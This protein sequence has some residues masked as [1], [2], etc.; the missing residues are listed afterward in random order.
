MLVYQ[1]ISFLLLI[2]NLLIVVLPTPAAAET[3]NAGHEIKGVD[4]NTADAEALAREL[5]GIGPKKA[6]AIVE[7]REKNG[8]FKSLYELDQVYGIG[9]KTIER[10]QEKIIIL[11]PEPSEDTQA[12]EEEAEATA[13]TKPNQSPAAES[14]SQEANEATVM[15]DD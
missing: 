13:A 8:P 14:A 4:I 2:L 6:A 12:S 1:K 15:D 3:V 10:N 9:K 11:V 7:F 5:D